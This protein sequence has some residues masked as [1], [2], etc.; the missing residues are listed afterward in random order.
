MKTKLTI[1]IIGVALLIACLDEEL[2]FNTF[3][4]HDVGN[5]AIECVYSNVSINQL[6]SI[7]DIFWNGE[8]TSRSVGVEKKLKT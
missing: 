5:S 4:N 8:M 6:K 1:G 7:S 3:S 2:S